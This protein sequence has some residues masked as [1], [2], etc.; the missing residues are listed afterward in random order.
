MILGAV[1]ILGGVHPLIASMMC[2]TAD[3][4]R[5]MVETSFHLSFINWLS[6][7]INFE[8]RSVVTDDSWTAQML[9]SR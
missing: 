2:I 7:D 8:Y 3:T 6:F 5:M 4:R 9:Y 1:M